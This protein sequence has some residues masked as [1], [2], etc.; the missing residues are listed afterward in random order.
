MFVVPINTFTNNQWLTCYHMETPDE[1]SKVMFKQYIP[2]GY[3]DNAILFVFLRFI[4][5]ILFMLLFQSFTNPETFLM[6][7][8]RGKSCWP[9]H[10]IINTY[11]SFYNFLL[12]VTSSQPCIFAGQWNIYEATFLRKHL[13]SLM[14]NKRN[15]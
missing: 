5:S 2:S 7:C 11:K 6:I 1:V 10:Q 3:V 12:L 14:H 8:V 15:G 4:L 9:C 13:R